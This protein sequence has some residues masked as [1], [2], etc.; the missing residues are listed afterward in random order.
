MRKYIGFYFFSIILVVVVFSEN[1]PEIVPELIH[2][3]Q[4]GTLPEQ[5]GVITRKSENT[6]APPIAGP[7]AIRFLD[8]GNMIIMDNINRRLIEYSKKFSVVSITPIDL[9]LFQLSI[10]KGKAVG[11]YAGDISLGRAFVADL[12]KNPPE[13]FE[14]EPTRLRNS[15]YS[16]LA[17]I[18]SMAI[19]QYES[20]EFFGLAFDKNARN[21]EIAD[22]ATIRKLI[23]SKR[24]REQDYI[25]GEEN[26]VFRDGQLISHRARYAFTFFGKQS[27][28]YQPF[29][30]LAN[31]NYLFSSSEHAWIVTTQGKI[32]REI[33]LPDNYKGL[34]RGLVS[35]PDGY[36]YF[37]YFGNRNSIEL[38]RIGPFSELTMGYIPKRATLNDSQVRLRG[39]PTIQGNILRYLMKGET[40]AILSRQETEETIG[41]ISNLWYK[42][43]CWDG[44][45]GWVF[46]AFLDIAVAPQIHQ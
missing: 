22:E 33:G 25:I 41:G 17:I 37:L 34:I 45:D 28:S 44:Q 21:V 15:S 20:G 46:G 23:S 31:G 38:Y 3:F 13:I 7:Q 2:T 42:V 6:D 39:I 43:R 10:D 36:I 5:L 24:S 12:E 26:A 30:A 8:N 1:L 14:F 9:W 27:F 40:V 11:W 35:S 29:D 18:D 16:F 19:F 32:L 4:L